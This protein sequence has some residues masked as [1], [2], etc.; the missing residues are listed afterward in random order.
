MKVEGHDEAVKFEMYII[1]IRNSMSDFTPTAL[2]ELLMDL[3][4]VEGT[5][6]WSLS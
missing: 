4:V 5:W 3:P 2:H 1:E 6:S